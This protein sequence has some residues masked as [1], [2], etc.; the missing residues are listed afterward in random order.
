MTLDEQLQADL[1]DALKA[2]DEDRKRT[3]RSVR[4]AVQNA[5][6]DARGPLDDA[7]VTAVLRKQAKQRRDAIA[8]FE[9]G[10]R[11]DLVASEQAE[12][13]IINGY[14]PPAMGE[15]DVEAAARAMIAQVGATGPSDMGKV[16]GPLTKSLA[17]QA[18]GQ[19]IS[20]V[21]RRLLAG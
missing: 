12:L 14:L 16:M 3:L 5:A 7:A 9:R 8:E 19:T 20:A 15:A 17:G 10:G 1:K 13:D 6:I 21:V 18:D 2:G 11:P 4:A